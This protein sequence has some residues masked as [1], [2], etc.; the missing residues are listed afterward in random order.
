MGLRLTAIVA[1]ADVSAARAL[2]VSLGDGPGTFSV[3]LS[4]TRGVTDPALATHYGMSGELYDGEGEALLVS[5]DPMVKTFSLDDGDFLSHIAACSP[6]LY[7]II[8]GI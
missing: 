2:C 7:R 1:A 3:P 4:T 6:P 8:E 5:I